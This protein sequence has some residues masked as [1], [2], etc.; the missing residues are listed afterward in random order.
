MRDLNT[1][2]SPISDS[3]SDLF[4]LSAYAS[5]LSEFISQIT[6][7]FTIGIYGEWGSGKT[8]FVKLLESFLT[9]K[10]ISSDSQ[11]VKFITFTAWPYKTSDELWRAIIIKIARELYEVDSIVQ[12][13]I[14]P[15][16]S[17]ETSFFQWIA[18][19]LASDAIVLRPERPEPDQLSEYK[20]LVAQLDSTLASSISKNSD[21]RTQLNQ[22]ETL[23]AF[24]KMAS[25]ALGSLSPLLA[26]LRS[27][28]G[29]DTQVNLAKLLQQEK[30]E[31]S[32]ERIESIREFQQ[33]F[34][35]LF[36]RKASG[37]RV[38]VFIDDLDRCAPD[39]SLDLLEAIK[40]LLGEVPCI[41]I[42]AADENLIGQG[43]R[44]R[45]KDLID[46]DDSEQTQSFFSQK[47]Q[48]YFEKIIQMPIRVPEKTP[49]QTHNFIVAQY[50]EWMPAT[51]IIQTAVG[52]NPRRL[53]QYCN[54]LQ[55]KYFVAQLDSRE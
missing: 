20:K 21:N 39:I 40:V 34:V 7:P 3:D 48:E 9:K 8:S 53:K 32:R 50:P 24:V 49:E 33:I 55:Y 18:R 45:F 26:G 25:A 42:V 19:L 27:L 5:K 23:F 1:F 30:N 22:E 43:L 15:S 11:P 2:D 17:T 44:L 28:F 41:F 36:K 54:L 29:L 51:D 47:G 52:N 16:N 35:N 14:L 37:K 12:P 31:V 10:E 46:K 6:P 4:G 38:C 13:E